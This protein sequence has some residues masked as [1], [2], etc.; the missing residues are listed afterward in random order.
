MLA[1]A[2]LLAL[3]EADALVLAE[4]ETEAL[5]LAEALADAETLVDCSAASAGIVSLSRV[6]KTSCCPTCLAAP[7]MVSAFT[8]LVPISPPPKI[9]ASVATPAASQVLP[10][11]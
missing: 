5:V 4:A 2:E 7:T 3:A 8:V 6:A 1:D 11:L 9:P 10:D